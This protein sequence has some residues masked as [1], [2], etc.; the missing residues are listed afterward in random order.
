L[1]WLRFIGFEIRVG[2][3]GLMVLKI[4]DGSNAPAGLNQRG[5]SKPANHSFLYHFRLN[6]AF[7]LNWF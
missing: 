4:G 3:V 6:R 7:I 2:E 5:I 1:I